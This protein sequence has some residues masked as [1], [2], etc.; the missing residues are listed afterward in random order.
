MENQRLYWSVKKPVKRLTL[1]KNTAT[2]AVDNKIKNV[3]ELEENKAKNVVEFIE[4]PEE[5]K[6]KNVVE[7][8][9]LPEENKVKNVVELQ[10]S[11][12]LP[13]LPNEIFLKIMSYLSTSDILKKMAPVSKRFYQ[14][15]QDK[16]VIKRMEFMAR[17]NWSDERK[18]KYHDDFFKVLKNSQKLKFLAV[19]LDQ[20]PGGNFYR[21]W[22]EASVNLQYVEEFY[23]KIR[24]FKLES[25]KNF[26]QYGVLDRCPKLKI[27]K[28]RI[29]DFP[30][31]SFDLLNTIANFNSKSLQKRHL[32]P[33]VKSTYTI[34]CDFQIMKNFLKKITETMPK[35]QH[36]LTPPCSYNWAASSS[37]SYKCGP[38][39]EKFF[40]EIEA[41]KK[42]K[43]EIW[44]ESYRSYSW[45]LS[46]LW[47]PPT[48]YF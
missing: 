27:L 48:L 14:L 6:V 12:L 42:I 3:M 5:N 7:Y 4:L 1:K 21:N 34:D 40:Q 37:W 39:L 11:D 20:N 22:I 32:Y 17:L 2:I 38:N 15:S 47:E 46:N 19:D 23:I 18:V 33:N 41:E 36:F 8:M 45:I 10:E 29:L 24:N 35:R 13:E 44:N 31:V 9:E 43:I 16:T 26:L 25:C 28:I 30:E